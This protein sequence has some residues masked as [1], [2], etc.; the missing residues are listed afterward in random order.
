MKMLFRS[1]P[2]VALLGALIWA[3]MAFC[4]RTIRWQIEGIDD[5]KSNWQRHGGLVVAAW[6]STILTL[7]TA[8]TRYL[9]HWPGRKASSA[10][11]ISMSPD[12]ESV[13]RAIQY[14][15]LKSIRGSSH[16][17]RK[18]R[19][20]GGGAAL[21]EAV[22]L[23]KAGGA[24][25]ITPDGPRGPRQRSGLG[26]ILIAKRANSA[27]LPY[28]LATSPSKRLSTWDRFQIPLP[29]ARG[30][31]VFGE[32]ID[33]AMPGTPEDMRHLLETRLNDATKRAEI[34]CGAR[35]IPPADT[36]HP[37]PYSADAA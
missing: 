31:I 11:L 10:M 9:R 21:S 13:A 35:H 16:Y 6:H 32:T 22:R 28:A 34:L 4:G 12:G 8:W 33:T 29:F 17:K 25:C 15:G 18:N 27:I 24:V 26:P 30:A 7:P 3:Y 1:G 20:K 14:L 19:D 37:K 23:L 36:S 5:A 2:V